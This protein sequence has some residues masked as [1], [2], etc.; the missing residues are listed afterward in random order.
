MYYKM[1]LQSS[2][3]FCLF[4]AIPLMTMVSCNSDSS[5]A[6]KNSIDSTTTTSTMDSTDAAAMVHRKKKGKVSALMVNDNSEKMVKDKEGVYSKTD[7]RPEYPG[8]EVALSKFIE[9][10]INYPQD[11]IDQNTEGTTTVTFIVNEK[12]MVTTPTVSGPSTGHGLDDEALRVISKMPTWK[13]GMVK[14]KAVKT[15]LR[16]PVTFK[17]EE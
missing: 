7:V 3:L 1:N 5:S 15:R 4:A 14:G 13:P 16:L 12:G 2:L 8:G 10:N 6:E 17:L 11:A 9:T